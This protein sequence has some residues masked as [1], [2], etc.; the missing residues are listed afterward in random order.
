MLTKAQG[1]S[2]WRCWACAEHG[3]SPLGEVNGRSRSFL[4]RTRSRPGGVR[5]PLNAGKVAARSMSFPH[6]EAG[7]ADEG[8]GAG[9]RLPVDNVRGSG[10]RGVAEFL[11]RGLD[12]DGTMRGGSARSRSRGEQATVATRCDRRSG[13][14][15]RS[16]NDGDGRNPTDSWG[17]DGGAP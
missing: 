6:D 4:D 17:C 14:L 5:P 11:R 15:R 1:L 13:E 3:R 9:R 12:D 2:Q 10:R 7:K 16:D 8:L